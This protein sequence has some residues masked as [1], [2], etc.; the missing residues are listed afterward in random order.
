MY[1]LNSA[2]G[3]SLRKRT[4]TLVVALDGALAERRFS[5]RS[6]FASGRDKPAANAKDAASTSVV[7]HASRGVRRNRYR[8]L[9][10]R[11]GQECVDRGSDLNIRLSSLSKEFY[12]GI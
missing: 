12:Q 7:T 2:G 9:P 1:F 6:S 8:Q 11:N 4:M 5:S 10:G 3:S